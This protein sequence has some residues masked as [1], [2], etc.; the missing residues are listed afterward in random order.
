MD[1]IEETSAALC[2]SRQAHGE[3]CDAPE[4]GT[5]Q[6]CKAATQSAFRHVSTLE[7]FGCKRAALPGLAYFG[8]PVC[9]TCAPDSLCAE[10]FR[11]DI[12]GD[13]ATIEKAALEHGG[14][15]GGEYLES[16]RQ[17]SLERLSGEQWSTF[18]ARVLDGYSAAL[19]LAVRQTPPF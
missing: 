3:Q 10:V 14:Q 4:A 13:L 11:N 8:R 15:A 5:C 17:F 2:R 18:L 6:A 12:D 7:C 19:R 9:A 1:L 16:I